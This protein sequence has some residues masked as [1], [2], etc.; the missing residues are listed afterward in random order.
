[1]EKFL[2][3]ISK[4]QTKQ[5]P[6]KDSEAPP[7]PSLPS[8]NTEKPSSSRSTEVLTE[9]VTNTTSSAVKRKDPDPANTKASKKRV[10]KFRN[11]WLESF[12]WI[13]EGVGPNN[14]TRPFCKI[15]KINLPN[16]YSHLERHQDSQQHT[17]LKQSLMKQPLIDNIQHT[18]NFKTKT[19]KIKTAELRV[20]MFLIQ[21]NLAISLI[22]PII[23]LIKAAASDSEIAKSLKCGN[24]T[25][26]NEEG[27]EEIGKIIRNQPFS[28]I[29][30]ETTDVS[31]TK[32][33]VLIV[34]YFD[35]VPHLYVMG[36][37][38]HS[39]HLCFSAASKKL[40]S[41][42]EALTRNI[43]SFFAHSPKR[44]L[45]LEEFQKYFS[46]E[47]HKILKMSSTR[48]LSLENVISRI[49]EQWVPLQHFFISYELESNMD[50]AH[51][52]CSEITEINKT[53]LSFLGYVLNITNKINIEFQAEAPKIPTIYR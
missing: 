23:D 8:V 22:S 38:C 11:A 19:N 33:L 45:E 30:D 28:L 43:Y 21:Y 32:C 52:I 1:M 53:Y 27:L 9:D 42:L 41:H 34:R 25:I 29:I 51:N 17:K 24:N 7:P 20:I 39:L 18:K 3:K 36:C 49:L 4:T 5:P 15:C 10:R 13:E 47:V 2:I 26:L 6:P 40:P 44:K 14:T 50:L 46:V 16:N 48:W 37:I 12:D 31:T 35:F